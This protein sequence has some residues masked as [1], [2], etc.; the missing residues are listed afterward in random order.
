[1]PQQAATGFEPALGCLIDPAL[2]GLA[3]QLGTL[4]GL[5]TGEAGAIHTAARTL[6]TRAAVRKVTRILM[7]ELNGARIRGQLQASDPAGR[8]A[9]W[10]AEA[11]KAGFWESLAGPYP[12][13][14][15]HLRTVIANGCT[16]ALSMAI[17][18]AADRAEFARLPGADAGELAEVT[19][20][21]GDSHNRGQTVTLLRTTAGRVV[22]K[23][24][25]V[26]VDSC[27]AR[28]LDVVLPPEA[29]GHSIR[30]PEVLARAGY[31]WAEHI[32]HRYC[33]D[34]AELR[35]FYQGIG[36]W[37]AVMRLVGGSDLHAENLIAC[38][39][40]P[41]VVD[42][43]TLF[44]PHA[45]A[46]PSGYGQAHDHA[47]Q[48]IADSAL[49][50]GL[51]P[52]RGDALAWRGVDSSALGALPGQQP[53]I[54]VPVIIGAGTDEARMGYERRP[55]QL[56]GNHPSQEPVLAQYWHHV[57]GGFTEMTARLHELD[58]AD[59]LTG[60]LRAFADCTVRVVVRNTE[61]Y[62]ELS[63]M[64]WHPASMH[65][66]QAA[67]RQ[68]ADLLAAHAANAGAAPADP[69]VIDAEIAEMLDGDVP[70]FT[71]TPRCGRLTGPRS[72]GYGQSQD[73]ISDALNRWRAN[74]QRLDLQV[75][76]G[77]LI[78]AYLNEGV[79]PSFR[80]LVTQQVSQD[81]LDGRRRRVAAGIMRTI[82]DAAI[83][84]ADGT[85]TWI[86]PVIGPTG[87]VTQ[88]LS[89][90]L[91]NGLAGI[92]VTT[93][94]YEFEVAGGRADPVEGLGGL[95]DDVLATLLLIEQQDQR[96]LAGELAVRPD[97]PGGYVGIGSLIWAW[98]LLGRLGVSGLDVADALGR[99][100][101]PAGRIAAAIEEDDSFDLFRGM[102]GAVV[103]LLRLTEWTGDPQWAALAR[104]IGTRLAGLARPGAAGARWGNSIYPEGIGGTAHGVT[105]TGWA[106]ARLAAHP[107]SRQADGQ[108]GRF[109]GTAAAAFA[110]EES[111]YDPAT[112]S[113]TDLREPGHI[114]AA[115]CHGAGGIGIIAA[116]LA[117]M[118]T[119]GPD[120]TGPAHWLEV[121]QRAARCSWAHGLGSNHTLCHGDLGVWEV[122][123]LAL[124]AGAAPDGLDRTG[125][126][127][128][129]I[130]AVG[131]HGPVSG[132]ARDTLNPGL[133][134]GIGGM[135]YQ[136][137]R[138]NPA[139]P[140]PS[141]LLP[142][143]GPARP[144]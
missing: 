34:G 8:W 138:M 22:Y 141:V 92:A 130:S 20:G 53:R 41:V 132:L 96:D 15:G 123:N 128:R 90:D 105:G 119:A 122:M 120:G 48:L 108:A 17:R 137:L 131:E 27:L 72:T 40:V 38:G 69:A 39:P 24:R 3:A 103:P 135:A 65:D 66:P 12:V 5:G 33:A 42:C 70:V 50:T 13:L 30:V 78:S 91:Y 52:G 85:V 143:P 86:A 21:V 126:D 6:V 74:D 140:L 16:A 58:R 121:L 112:G 60:P 82:R 93:A 139:S 77:T 71:T 110:F 106:L 113:W 109:A 47:A 25:S 35:G 116:D 57:V 59:R 14:L 129:I 80:P 49:R 95:L 51:L 19:F 83:R 75:I 7:L 56:A 73:L 136:L 68:A 89:N 37:L 125:L 4:P 26:D 144:L 11:T 32:E 31:G 118:G 124:E 111:L 64:L 94:G 127:A 104:G 29:D 101:A 87:W 81:D 114:T 142:D 76:S 1:M 67:A 97:V 84:A 133:L 107:A 115:W 98:L 99:A 36:H 102:P 134:P 45:P 79:L 88:P 63:R 43:E 28:L 46:T 117:R 10:L 18:F 44:T 54:D 2:A 55:A 62:M 23:P 61:T 9:E 100:L